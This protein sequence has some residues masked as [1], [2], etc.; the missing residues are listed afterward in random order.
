MLKLKERSL[1]W[2]LKHALRY[3]ETDLL[4]FPFEFAAIS[5]DWVAIKNFLKQ[6]DVLHW[7]VRPHRTL[8]APK[9]NYGFRI[10]T[11]L[12][13]L[14][15]LVFASLIYEIAED[16]EAHRVPIGRVTVFSYRVA[17]TDD[18]QL[19]DAEID[20]EDF[21]RRASELLQESDY[22]HVAVILQIS[23]RES[24]YIV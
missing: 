21:R 13:P 2:A 19:F 14:D 22:S 16:I 15:F 11:Q 20:Y 1:E 7:P 3:R 12:D 17:I 24:I 4:P 18:G 8:L 5:H 10:V 23:I 6:A 9:S